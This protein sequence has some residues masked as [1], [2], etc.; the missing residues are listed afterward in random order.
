MSGPGWLLARRLSEIAGAPIPPHTLSLMRHGLTA[1]G[2]HAMSA[3]GLGAMV[4]TQVVLD[5]LFEWA[6]V[7]PISSAERRVA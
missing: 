3:L 4:P 5:D 1:D 7:T 2:G 6:T